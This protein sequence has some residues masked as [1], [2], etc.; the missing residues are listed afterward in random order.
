M[1]GGGS[2]RG[3]THG[4]SLGWAGSVTGGV[5]DLGVLGRGVGK[6]PV[7]AAR[8][9][10]IRSDVEG[11]ESNSCFIVIWVDGPVGV[12]GGMFR[13][14]DESSGD[15]LT[16]CLM[17]I[18]FAG[19]IGEAVLVNSVMTCD[20]ALLALLAT[21]DFGFCD[22][23][24]KALG[25]GGSIETFFDVGFIEF[26]VGGTALVPDLTALV[27]ARVFVLV[28]GRASEESVFATFFTILLRDDTFR[29]RIFNG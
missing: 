22:E 14:G 17:V 25:T 5:L 21:V 6:L 26:F 18:I 24:T 27:A 12:G 3:L 13:F 15:S 16:C 4:W 19:V 29:P 10:A 8:R 28:L 7:F 23:R 20:A 9:A 1:V 2:V 11:L